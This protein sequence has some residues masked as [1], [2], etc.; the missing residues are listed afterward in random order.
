MKR[1]S[2]LFLLLAGSLPALASWQAVN[3]GLGSM[4]VRSIFAYQDTVMAGTASGIFR[5]EDGTSWSAINGNI[6][7]T[8]IRDLRGGGGPRVI[9]ASTDSGAYFTQD[10]QE[11]FPCASSGPGSGAINY[12]W[13]GADSEEFNWALGTEGQGVFAGP[14][15]DGPWTAFNNGLSGDALFVNDLSGYDDDEIS[16]RVIATDAGIFLSM[17]NM[18]SW[19]DI[20]DGL[21]GAE[22]QAHRVVVLGTLIMAATDGGL[23]ATPDYGITWYS[24]VENPGV[25][26]TVALYPFSSMALAFGDAGYQ[27][28]DF[29]TYN[30]LDMSGVSG[31]PI[32]CVAMT[33]TH[34]YVGTRSGGVFREEIQNLSDIADHLLAGPRDYRL[35][36][37]FPNPF[38]PGTRIDYSLAQAGQVRILVH[39]LLGREVRAI[40]RGPQAMGPHG[41]SFDAGALPSVS[42][43]YSLEVNQRGRDTRRMTLVK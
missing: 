2:I 13:F 4:D 37:N 40:D 32:T 27:A 30:P 36:G 26:L 38:N 3:T 35:L 33:T 22:L 43:F 24:L 9:W 7:N 11:Y 15:L 8:S 14:E 6:G 23:I 18:A 25:F 10:Q 39:D 21:S 16:P 34:V 41:F 42:Y 31:G 12:F 17:D 29:F 20:N 5:S 19:T 28:N 1:P